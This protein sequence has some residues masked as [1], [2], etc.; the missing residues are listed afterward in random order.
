MSK[1]LLYISVL[2][3]TLLF[4]TLHSAAQMA[5]P[6]NVCVG[7]TKT[8]QVND[9]SVPSTYTWTINGVT[10]AT[11]SNKLTKTWDVEGTY[12]ITVQEHSADGCDGDIQE[13]YVYVHPPSVKNIDTTVC[14]SGLP[15]DWNGQQISSAGQFSAVLKNIWGCDSTVNLKVTVT[16]KLVPTFDDLTICSGT[17]ATL[18]GTSKEGIAGTWSPATIDNTKSGSY[19]F[20]PT[21]P[22]AV[23]GTLKVTV[24]DKLVPTF[25]D[26][27]ICSGT[28]AT[29]PGTS[30]EGIA[31]TWSPATIDNTKSRQ[32]HV[33]ANRSVCGEWHPEGDGD[34]QAGTRL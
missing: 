17:A 11:T 22:C 30:K 6:D 20:T 10:Q 32:L 14:E 5:M 33:H 4:C 31:G 27:T 9:P 26:I 1:R 2:A 3:I 29:L 24:T 8:Y 18:P 16:A 12:L 13:G 21:D 19:T 15:F 28:A 23:S 25:D 34:R 7:A